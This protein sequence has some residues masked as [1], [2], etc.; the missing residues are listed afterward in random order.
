MKDIPSPVPFGECIL[1]GSVDVLGALAEEP[2]GR[3][4]SLPGVYDFVALFSGSLDGTLDHGNC[5]FLIIDDLETVETFFQ[6][7]K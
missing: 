3:Y 2:V 1:V 4:Q 6:D 7:V 5:R